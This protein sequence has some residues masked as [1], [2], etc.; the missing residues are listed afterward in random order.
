MDIAGVKFDD[1]QTRAWLIASL[2]S[3]AADFVFNEP[4]YLAAK[5]FFFL[6]LKLCRQHDQKEVE[7]KVMKRTETRVSM[8]DLI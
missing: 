5:T 3:F 7:A 8:S 6:M 2:I 1:E 4:L